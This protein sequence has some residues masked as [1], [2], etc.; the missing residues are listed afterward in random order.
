MKHSIQPKRLKELFRRFRGKRFLV[1]GDLMLDRY[2]YGEVSRISPEA[3]VPVVRVIS[4]EEHLG[5]AANVA[6]NLV[7][8]GAEVSICGVV[9]RDGDGREIA[10]HLKESGI[11]TVLLARQEGRPT[12][13]KIRIIAHQQQVVRVDH[14][15]DDAMEENTLKR[16]ARHIRGSVGN[17]DGVIL[18]DYGKGVV[19]DRII[20][21][22]VGLCESKKSIFVDPKVKQFSNYQGVSLVTPNA[23]EAGLASGE[24]IVD[25]ASLLRAGRRLLQMLPGTTILLTRGEKGMSLFEPVGRVTHIPTVAREVYDVTGAGDTVISTFAVATVAGASKLEAAV[26]ANHA[27]GAVVQQAGAATVDVDTLALLFKGE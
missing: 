14:E 9:G 12:T 17:V 22:V 24:K 11:G 23:S 6:N 27:A 13:R 21:L 20:R 10:R 16:L 4:E 19:S 3:P 18:S 15:Q 26:L 1:I 25:D 5:G 2:V 7:A 8:L